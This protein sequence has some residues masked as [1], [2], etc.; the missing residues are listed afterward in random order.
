MRNNFSVNYSLYSILCIP[1]TLDK[2]QGD[3]LEGNPKQMGGGTSNLQ[4]FT[5]AVL[6]SSEINHVIQD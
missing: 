5:T 6:K 1:N 3:T 2:A 4:L